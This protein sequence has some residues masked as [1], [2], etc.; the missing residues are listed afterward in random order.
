MYISKLHYAAAP[1]TNTVQQQM[2]TWTCCFALL[3]DLVYHQMVILPDC[4]A[5]L[6][7]VDI[8]WSYSGNLFSIYAC[9]S[10]HPTN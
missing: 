1:S 7:N 9:I 3:V 8:L 6:V 4:L 2:S 10:V 5:A